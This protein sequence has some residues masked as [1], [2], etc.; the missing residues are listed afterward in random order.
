[1]ENIS[2][3]FWCPCPFLREASSRTLCGWSKTR[4]CSC[5]SS[6]T[7]PKLLTFLL[8]RRLAVGGAARACRRHC[9]SAV[10]TLLP[11]IASRPDLLSVDHACSSFMIGARKLV[12]KH[13]G[14]FEGAM[15]SVMQYFE[16]LRVEGLAD[17]AR[18]ITCRSSPSPGASSSLRTLTQLTVPRGDTEAKPVS[19]GGSVQK[20]APCA[21]RWH[22]VRVSL[23]T[24]TNHENVDDVRL[25]MRFVMVGRP[26]RN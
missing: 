5:C 14:D 21:R 10:H 25:E 4:A 3:S 7:L 20:R 8:A 18:L 24:T 15:I 13:R 2:S 23:P 22:P 16:L 26:S 17:G 6:Q 9:W 12:M 11:R 19:G 1:M